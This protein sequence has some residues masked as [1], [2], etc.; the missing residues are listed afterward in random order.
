MLGLS[1]DMPHQRNQARIPVVL[2]S[3][4]VCWKQALFSALSSTVWQILHFEDTVDW[5]RMRL[6]GVL[7]LFFLFSLL[8]SFLNRGHS[9]VD[10]QN[11]IGAFPLDYRST[12][13]GAIQY[14]AWE[15]G[16]GTR[17]QDLYSL[18]DA[19]RYCHRIL[20]YLNSTSNNGTIVNVGEGGGIG[21][22][23]NSLMFAVFPALMLKRNLRSMHHF[24]HSTPSFHETHLLG[25]HSFVLK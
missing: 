25:E 13:G 23:F 10:N 16:F 5:I 11:D 2:S 14:Y 3:G 6:V 7:W 22:K 20:N 4:C 1:R 12:A 8:R 21:H 9:E 17:E 24:L 18:I 15:D 19:N